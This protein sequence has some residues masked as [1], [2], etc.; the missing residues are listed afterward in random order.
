MSQGSVE[1]SQGVKKKGKKRGNGRIGRQEE[2]EEEVFEG[3]GKD[4]R[5]ENESGNKRRD[6]GD[7]KREPRS[8]ERNRTIKGRI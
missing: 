8:Q 5:L 3:N 2:E 4:T 6:T 7:A 1:A